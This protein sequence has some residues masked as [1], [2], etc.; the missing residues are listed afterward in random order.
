M[1]PEEVEKITIENAIS[2]KGLATVS[3][4][5]L[6]DVDKMIKHQEKPLST[7]KLW[8]MGITTSSLIGFNTYLLLES[9]KLRL[10]LETHKVAHDKDNVTITKDIK[11][12]SEA[13]KKNTEQD[14]YIVG[15]LNP[16]RV[17]L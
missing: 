2:I 5:I 11:K 1:T 14:K 3:E 13:V 17:S 9:Q 16:N 8:L 4:Q 6:R 15:R 7:W 10:D 12:L